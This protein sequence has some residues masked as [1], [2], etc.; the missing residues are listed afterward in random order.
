MD[1]LLHLVKF[2]GPVDRFN[3]IL[4]GMLKGFENI[5]KKIDLNRRYS[6][7]FPL[8]WKWSNIYL[9]RVEHCEAKLG[10]RRDSMCQLEIRLV[11]K[12]RQMRNG[13]SVCWVRLL[14]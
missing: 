3:L 12:H 2:V 7:H 9:P 14:R 11:L 10:L 8:K 6:K 4:S 1:V 13:Q 5:T